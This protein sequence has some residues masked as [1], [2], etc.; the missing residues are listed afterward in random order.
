MVLDLYC[1]QRRYSYGHSPR[2]DYEQRLYG[3]DLS[4]VKIKADRM[5][6]NAQY[7]CRDILRQYVTDD[8]VE[9]SAKRKDLFFETPTENRF[10]SNE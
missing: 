5:C 8:D 1:T 3:G 7:L 6:M 4:P 10:F 9:R 2:R